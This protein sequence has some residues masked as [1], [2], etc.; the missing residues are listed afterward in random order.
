MDFTL[1]KYISLVNAL[2]TCSLPFCRFG[3][4]HAAGTVGFIVLRHDVDRKPG[5]AL[6]M[7]VAEAEAGIRASYHFRA[8]ADG[9]QDSIIADIAALGHEIAYHYE[10]LSAVTGRHKAS[11]ATGD[12]EIIALALE[13]YHKNLAHLRTLYPVSVISMHGSPLSGIDNRLLWKYHDYHDDGIV[14]EPYFDID[15]SGVLYLTDT[16]R[17]WNG[18]DSAVR[19]RGIMLN[20]DDDRYEGWKARPVRG[21]LM[22]MTE[23]GRRLRDKYCTGRT[24]GIISLATHGGLPGR[25]IINTHPQRWND[26]FVPWLIELIFQNLKNLIKRYWIVPK[27]LA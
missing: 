23:E 10:D 5:N 17:K 11:Q 4:I 9:N 1:K 18:E 12:G 24:D 6:A 19:D 22:C 27:F 13:R 7:A 25:M 20:G 21:S 14:C 15:V 16:G 2:K 26:R 8:T 3:D